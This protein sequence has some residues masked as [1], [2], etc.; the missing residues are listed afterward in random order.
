MAE[1]KLRPLA[2]LDVSLTLSFRRF[3]KEHQSRYLTEQH[4]YSIMIH[5][6]CQT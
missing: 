6:Q 1:A 3:P 4:S 5:R 2:R